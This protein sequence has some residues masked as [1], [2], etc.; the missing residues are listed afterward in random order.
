MEPNRTG[1]PCPHPVGVVLR[2]VLRAIRR[3]A[4][5]EPLT[6]ATNPGRAADQASGSSSRRTPSTPVASTSSWSAGSTTPAP[7]SPER[8]T[9]SVSRR[10]TGRA[11]RRHHSLVVLRPGVGRRALARRLAE[12]APP[13]D[14]AHHYPEPRAAPHAKKRWRLALR[15][16]PS[17]PPSDSSATRS[18]GKAPPERRQAPGA[19]GTLREI[20][21]TFAGRPRSPIL[22]RR[23][24]GLGGYRLRRFR[25]WQRGR[26]N[27]VMARPIDGPTAP[28]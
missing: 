2:A 13:V 20:R 22:E 14:D 25:V 9:E 23:S 27:V 4:L 26:G 12:A 15:A 28:R 3:R 17:P 6:T 24:I 18:T 8:P 16:T 10:A 19:A 7:S 1:A 5:N 11:R 21:R